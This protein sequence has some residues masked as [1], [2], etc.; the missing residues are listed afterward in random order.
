MVREVEIVQSG[1][2]AAVWPIM[3]T[4]ELALGRAP[5][6]SRPRK[7]NAKCP[8]TGRKTLEVSKQSLC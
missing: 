5:V 1:A 4:V 7:S 8:A 6:M 2:L 3:E